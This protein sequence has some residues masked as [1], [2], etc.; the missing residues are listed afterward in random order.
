M[1]SGSRDWEGKLDALDVLSTRTLGALTRSEFD[2]VSLAKFLE[3]VRARTTVKKEVAASL[4]LSNEAEALIR[5]EFF[6][7]SLW[8]VLNEL[9]I[10]C[11]AGALL[12]ISG[13]PHP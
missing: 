1:A 5:D 12:T 2:C 8:H 11:A 10:K 7:C 13:T 3:R 6:D 4:F 9:L